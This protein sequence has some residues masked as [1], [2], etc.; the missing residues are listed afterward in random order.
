MIV[1]NALFGETLT[2]LLIIFMIVIAS[3]NL[4]PNMK[5]TVIKFLLPLVIFSSACVFSISVVLTLE[6]FLSFLKVCI[7]FKKSKIQID[8]I[9]C[10]LLEGSCEC[11]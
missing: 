2:I 4:D 7:A 10:F 8:I 5:N 11:L 1:L 9:G 3:N 6:M